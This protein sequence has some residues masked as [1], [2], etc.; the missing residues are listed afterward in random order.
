MQGVLLLKPARTEPCDVCKRPVCNCPSLHFLKSVKFSAGGAGNIGTEQ[1][2]LLT[3]CKH[4]DLLCWCI[5]VASAIEPPSRTLA[6][7]MPRPLPL[8]SLQSLQQAIPRPVPPTQS[9]TALALAADCSGL[10]LALRGGGLV[11]LAVGPSGAVKFLSVLH[12]SLVTSSYELEL[13]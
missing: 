9:V 8:L 13:A 5:D 2:R 11:A 4:G 10:A 6:T 1:S 7:A 3:L 12:Q